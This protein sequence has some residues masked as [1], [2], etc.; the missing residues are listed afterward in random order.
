MKKELTMLGVMI[1]L[2]VLTAVLNPVFL[3]A[4]TCATRSDTS[5]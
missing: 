1:G 2:G 3:G 5:R 4:T